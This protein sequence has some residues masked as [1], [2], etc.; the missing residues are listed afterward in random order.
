MDELEKLEE[1]RAARK[2]ASAKARAAQRIEDLKAFYALEEE[3]GDDCVKAL[4]APGYKAGLPTL[5]VVKTPSSGQ[6]KRFQDQL[7]AAAQKQN[8]K[9]KREAQD[10]FAESCLAYPK[11][12]EKRAALVEAFPA[13]L[14]TVAIAANALA[15]FKSDEEGKG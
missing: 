9:G 2:A 6:Y 4:D 11:E 13:L 12:P 15:E 7:S 10:L 3:L 1:Q 5:V 14:V 8:A